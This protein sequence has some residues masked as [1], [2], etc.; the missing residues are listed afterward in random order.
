VIGPDPAPFLVA[1]PDLVENLPELEAAAAG[2]G[3]FNVRPDP[4]GVF[5]RVPL[6]MTVE[7]HVRLGLAPELLRVA[8]GGCTLRDPHERGRDRRRRARRPA[9]AD[10]RATGRSGPT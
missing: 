6:V 8:T 4:D 9:R 10:G 5:R 1:F 2:R 3:V 7:G